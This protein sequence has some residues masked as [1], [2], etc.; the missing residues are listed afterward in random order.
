MEFLIPFFGEYLT[1]YFDTCLYQI[2]YI[3]FLLN[4][5][6]PKRIWN[7]TFANPVYHFF[8]K[9]QNPC[10][11]SIIWYAKHLRQTTWCSFIQKFTNLPWHA[12]TQRIHSTWMQSNIEHVIWCVCNVYELI[13]SVDKMM[14]IKWEWINTSSKSN[15]FVSMS[16]LSECFFYPNPYT[17]ECAGYFKRNRCA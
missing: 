8:G 15:Q 12:F 14:E 1:K 16:S 6:M 2:S 9:Y 10:G 4:T 11:L 5:K 3:S 17:V 13:E 7:F